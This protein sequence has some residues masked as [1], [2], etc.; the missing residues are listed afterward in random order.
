[1]LYHAARSCYL[2]IIDLASLES[3][4]LALQLAIFEMNSRRASSVPNTLAVGIRSAQCM[5]SCHSPC[6]P[7]GQLSAS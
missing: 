4:Q 2:D 6:G 3:V 5:V 1:M 7:I